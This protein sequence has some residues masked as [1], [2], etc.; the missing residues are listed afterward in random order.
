MT[1]SKSKPDR[2]FISTYTEVANQAGEVVMSMRGK[3][4]MK[5]RDVPVTP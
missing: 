1:H 2:G 5:K 4:M 3:T